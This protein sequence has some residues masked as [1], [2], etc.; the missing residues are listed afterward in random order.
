ME[1]DSV[2]EMVGVIA[3]P[4]FN[5]SPGCSSSMALEPWKLPKIDESNTNSDKPPME[6][7]EQLN[8]EF[9]EDY[10]FF[11]FLFY[12]QKLS[13]FDWIKRLLPKFSY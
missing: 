4:N 10:F 2:P 8:F 12:K 13:C 3:L 7:Y 6:R 11:F 5:S 1:I 9:F